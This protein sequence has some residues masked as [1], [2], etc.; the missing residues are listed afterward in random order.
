MRKFGIFT[1]LGL[2]ALLLNTNTLVAQ[3]KKD[4]ADYPYWIEMMQDESVNFYDVQHAFEVYWENRPITKGCGWK[5]FKR[6]EYRMQMGRINPDGSRKDPTRILKAYN[7]FTKNTR[8]ARSG[9]WE[10]L[11]PYNLPGNGRSYQGLGRINAIAFHPTDPDVIFI[12]APA[13]GIWMTDQGGNNWVNLADDLPTLGV[14]SI[15]VDYTNPQIIY[16]GTGDRDAGDA[17]GMGVFKSIDGGENWIQQITMP[18]ATVG[19]MVQHKTDPLKIFAATSSGIYGTEDGGMSWAYQ[20]SGNFKQIVA[21]PDNPSIMYATTSGSFY[22]TDDEGQSWTRTTEGLSSGSRGVIAVTAANPAVVYFM[23]SNSANGFK[24]IYR[25]TDY[26]VTFVM[27]ADSPNILEWSCSGGSSGGQGWY[28]L[29]LEADPADEFAVYAGGV[30]VWMSQDGGQSWDIK[31]HWAGDCNEPTVHA[32]QHIFQF[33][34]VDGNLYIGNDGG[35]YKTSP[36]AESF[37]LLT[38]GLAISQVYKIG[39]SQTDKDMI[40]NGYQDNGTSTY[41]GTPFWKAVLGGDGM[42][43]LVDWQDDTYSYGTIYYGSISRL[44]NN[45]YDGQIGGQGTGGITESG[46]WVTPFTLHEGDPKILFGGYKNIWRTNNC[47]ANYVSWTKISENLSGSDENMKV[48]EHSPADFDLF[49][50][51]RGDGKVFR[52]ENI[53]ADVPEWTNITSM[54]PGNNS[55]SDIECHAYLPD[56]VYLSQ[57]GRI[58]QSNDR[59]NNWEDISENL[60]DV[61]YTSIAF[62]KNSIDGI[63]VSSNIGVFYRDFYLNEWVYFS[64]GLP[65]DASV[66]EVEI[67]T[68]ENNSAADVIRAGTYG[69]GTWTSPTYH[70]QPIA[71]FI[72]LGETTIPQGGEVAF[73][74][75]SGGIPTSFQWTFEGG[76][77]AVSTQ[78]NPVVTYPEEGVFKV[79]LSVSNEEGADTKVIEDMVIVSSSILPAAGFYSDDRFGCSQQ[80]VHL[81]DTSLYAPQSWQWSFTPYDVS[82]VE[83]TSA[84]SQNPVVIFNSPVNYSVSLEVTNMNGTNEVTAEDYIQLGGLR[85]PFEEDFEAAAGEGYQWAIENPDGDIGWAPFEFEDGNHSMFMNFFDY[86]KLHARDFLISPPLNLSDHSTA[87]LNIDYAYTNKLS[88]YDSLIISASADCGD[89]Y[90]RIFAS[91]ENGSGNFATAEPSSVNFVPQSIDDWCG[92]AYGANC[93]ALDISQY[94]GQANV[95]LRFETYNFFGNNLYI[96][97]VMVTNDI[98][99]INVRNETYSGLQISP[100]PAMNNIK[101][102][103]QFKSGNARISLIDATGKTVLSESRSLESGSPVSLDIS[104]MPAGMY[105]LRMLTE[106]DVYSETLIIK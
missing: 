93:I 58:Y 83:G 8:M 80:P 54:L 56:V 3:D 49:F 81:F 90:T 84:N 47:R 38:N 1:M 21:S 53:N 27:Q 23:Q 67:Y 55:P 33:S 43:C 76:E 11:G 29:S 17:E 63:Y 91:A 44:R 78:R 77:P 37:D 71:N 26:G 14:S 32:D 97:N 16:I 62:Y 98:T 19:A 24:A 85:L 6:W 36:E 2:M 5:P 87:L 99:S 45:N 102:S 64:D 60:P 89:T 12:G 39:Q 35:I 61:N 68:E 41:T 88:L 69:R 20:Q 52:S 86:K 100:N 31:A 94:A 34:P 18:A 106:Q 57:A 42:E 92:Q 59:G 7:Q 65:I 101:I 70:Y 72:S 15:I 25:S 82:Y 30:N 95:L 66:N 104:Q 50:A 9:N 48:I 96:D 13:G 73:A 28:D 51:I 75:R 103:G 4:L 105:L 22:R 40:I 10:C 46:A 79:T 74:D